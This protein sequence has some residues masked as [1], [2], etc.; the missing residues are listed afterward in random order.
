[1]TAFEEASWWVYIS[2]LIGVLFAAASTI[3]VV[4]AM[5][6]D[7]ELESHAQTSSS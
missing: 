7:G 1:M 4:P 3:V 6:A 2:V 5:P